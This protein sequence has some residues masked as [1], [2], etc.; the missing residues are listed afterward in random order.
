MDRKFFN[1][2]CRSLPMTTYVN[3]WRGSQVWKIGHKV[4]AIENW[5]RG[6]L[7]GITFKVSDTSFEHLK[8]VKGIRPAPY[9]ASRGLKWAQYYLPSSLPD[10]VLQDY[11]EKS[12]LIVSS[13]LPI[14][15]R[16][17]LKLP[18]QTNR[19]SARTDLLL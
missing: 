8:A 7:G 9:F 13:S 14:K 17:E 1:I 3:Q 18:I 16:R 6:N 12:Y 2:F 19:P 11:I 15:L 4:F 10:S 5:P